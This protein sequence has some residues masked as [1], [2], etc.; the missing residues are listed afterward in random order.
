MVHLADFWQLRGHPAPDAIRLAPVVLP[1]P[2]CLEPA[3][4]DSATCPARPFCAGIHARGS[5]CLP[6]VAALARLAR[7]SDCPAVWSGL[8]MG[9][10]LS[11]EVR[12]Y[13]L[14]SPLAMLALWMAVCHFE[15]P[16]WR[17]A[18][19]LALTMAALFWLSYTGGMVIL[20]TGMFVLLVYRLRLRSWLLP[21]TLTAL[22]V[23]PELLRISELLVR[24]VDNTSGID[25][26]PPS[27][28]PLSNCTSTS[29]AAPGR[30]QQ[31]W[32][33]PHFG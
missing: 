9:I 28:R 12:G 15:R 21:G 26:P 2:G 11:M 33:L 32:L 10:Q 8:G 22:L 3:R 19:P 4:R 30:L 27:C 6:T 24:R 31:R 16:G 29:S 17:R 23:L 1:D 18:L 14:Q 20:L 7:G 13:A 25:L 5:D